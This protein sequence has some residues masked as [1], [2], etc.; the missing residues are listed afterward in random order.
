[1]WQSILASSI[2]LIGFIVIS[3]V[4]YYLLNLSKM[5][6]QKTHFSE[7]HTSLERGQK[8][9]L[10]NGIF[11]RLDKVGKETVDVEL[12]SG[13]IMEVSRYAISRIIK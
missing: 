4:I 8:V 13:A 1:M 9:E 3:I 6:K 10:S 11:G 2:T 5:K 12:K 7:L